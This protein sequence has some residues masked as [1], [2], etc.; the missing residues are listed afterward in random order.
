MVSTKGIKE[1]IKKTYKK[2]KNEKISPFG[3]INFFIFRFH[4]Y[5]PLSLFEKSAPSIIEMQQTF[6]NL[7]WP[8][9]FSNI[10]VTLP[11][12]SLKI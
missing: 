5:P 1:K 11:D 2:R 8:L 9:N 3:I 7:F 6:Q 4:K 10:R 12:G